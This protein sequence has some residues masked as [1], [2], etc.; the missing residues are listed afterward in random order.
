M[1]WIFVSWLCLIGPGCMDSR[2]VDLIA[3]QTDQFAGNKCLI[4]ICTET[5][6]DGKRVAWVLSANNRTLAT[7]K[8]LLRSVAKENEQ[9]HISEFELGTPEV[10]QGIAVHVQ[11]H[12][13]IEEL[14]QE[15]SF[16]LRLRHPDPFHDISETLAQRG[17]VVIDPN[18]TMAAALQSTSLQV[19][20]VASANQVDDERLVIVAEGS[21]WNSDLESAATAWMDEGRFVLVLRT[22]FGRNVQLQNLRR[23]MSK[24]EF[25]DLN[26]SRWI[27]RDLDVGCWTQSASEQVGW[28]L[29][30]D[31]NAMS[32]AP[33]EPHP[34]DAD[35]SDDYAQVW[36]FVE[37][38]FQSG[39]ACLF[40]GLP[41]IENWNRSPVSRELLKTILQKYHK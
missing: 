12:L 38:Q 31:S 18:Q 40:V 15:S 1:G 11:L 10:R 5:P 26:R 39:G 22:M 30:V 19:R 21:Q 23:G 36:Q 3:G 32:L 35:N 20:C 37:F 9:A 25:T 14:I 33:C 27:S 7:G 34:D 29:L 16:P 17:I 6:M 24:M 2:A 28:R 13:K 4:R 8:S 41:L